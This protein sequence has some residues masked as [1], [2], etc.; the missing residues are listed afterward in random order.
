MAV[1]CTGSIA[2]G[3]GRIRDFRHRLLGGAGDDMLLGGPGDDRLDG[4]PGRDFILG[5]SDWDVAVYSDSP[6][7]VTIF[8]DDSNL[9]VGNGGHA[10]GDILVGIE[11]VTGSDHDD[12]LDGTNNSKSNLL[13]GGAGD[14]ALWGGGFDHPDTLVGGPGDDQLHAIVHPGIMEGG[15]GNDT[16][17]YY[18][19]RVESNGEIKDFT[20]GDDMISLDFYNGSVSGADLDT[21][22]QGSSG[23]VLDLSLLGPEFVDFGSITLNVPVSTLDASD[24][25]IA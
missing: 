14:D 18:G 19:S 20:K 1:Q 8:L 21:M 11:G 7:G 17:Q 12:L 22:L 24:F 25:I 13:D 3:P 15:P 9:I 23:N 4:G 16:F 2:P 5:G 10:E 6:D